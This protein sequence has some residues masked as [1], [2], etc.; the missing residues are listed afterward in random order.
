MRAHVLQLAAKHR[1]TLFWLN[2][3]GHAESFPEGRY[4]LVPEISS[5][6]DYLVALHELGHVVSQV[7]RRLVRSSTVYDYITMEGAAWA[8]AAEHADPELTGLLT[9]SDW[10]V[11]LKCWKS[12]LRWGITRPLDYADHIDGG[13]ATASQEPRAASVRHSGEQTNA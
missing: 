8:W 3:W 2:E 12:N 1:I 4:A 10:R 13:G 9:A 6:A 5:A 11:L 7:A